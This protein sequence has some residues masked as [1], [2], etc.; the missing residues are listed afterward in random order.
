M[1]VTILGSTG[2]IGTHVAEHLAASKVDF[3]TPHRDADLSGCHLGT[4][5][6]CAGLTA[7]FRRKP[8]QTVEAHVCKLLRILES[9]EFDSLTYLSSTRIYRDDCQTAREDDGIVIWPED[10]DYLYNASKVMGE[11]L[12][13][14][15]RK[16]VKVV[17]LSNVYGTD[18]HSENFLTSV[19]RDAVQ[20]GKVV[21]RTALESAKDYISIK[22]AAE[23]IARVALNGKQS[24]YNVACGMNTANSQIMEAVKAVTGC[25]IIVQEQAKARVFP[26]IDV[27]RIRTEF[28]YKRSDIIRDIPALVKAFGRLGESVNDSDRS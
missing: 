10:P 21:L 12:L 9:V 16:N 5:I 28:G 20:T 14:S 17:R 27:E 23:L 3:F 8:L 22:D 4:V 6:Y 24:I 25:E 11:S 7:D 26:V 13:L 19:L 2:F 15:S 18:L 1:S